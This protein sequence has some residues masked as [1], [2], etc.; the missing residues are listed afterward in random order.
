M[1][2]GSTNVGRRPSGPSPPATPVCRRVAHGSLVGRFVG[3]RYPSDWHGHTPVSGSRRP[4]H[5]SDGLGG[6]PGN[7]VDLTAPLRTGRTH[8]ERKPPPC[9]GEGRGFR[10]PSFRSIGAAERVFL[11]PERMVLCDATRVP[12]CRAGECVH[13]RPTQG[14]NAWVALGMPLSA[15]HR[16]DLIP[17]LVERDAVVESRAVDDLAVAHPHEPGVSVL[18]R[19]VVD[20]R[21]ETVPQNDDGVVVDVD[22]ADGHRSERVS[23]R[24]TPAKRGE[25]RF[26]GDGG[27]RFRLQTVGEAH[28]SHRGS[29][30]T[31]LEM[32][33]SGERR[34]GSFSSSE[35]ESLGV[36]GSR[37][38][39]SG[40][41]GGSRSRSLPIPRAFRPP[42]LHRITA[43]PDTWLDEAGRSVDDPTVLERL[44]RLAIPPAWVDV[45]A[46]ADTDASVQATGVDQRGRTQYRYSPAAQHLA[47]DYKFARM[48]L[49]AAAMPALRLQV[50]HDIARYR[51]DP[52]G[53]PVVTAAIVRLLDRGLLRV[54][55]D[56]YAR[57][58]HTY[59]LTTLRRSHVDTR[60][61]TIT[62]HFIGKERIPHTVTVRDQVTAKVVGALV[63]AAGNET[64]PI[65]VVT[66][67]HG[68]HHVT[69]AAVNAYLHA[70][71]QAP[72]S[73]K[74]FRTWGATV[75]AV[76][77]LA[78]AEAPADVSARSREG[79]AVGA[80]AALLGDT[81]S[82]TRS[83]YIHP[84]WIDV[85]RSDLVAAA[86]V[87]S[88]DRI[89]TR[90]VAS[91]FTDPGVQAAVLSGIT[92]AT[93]EVVARDENRSA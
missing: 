23:G 26:V 32:P 43:R 25:H 31:M 29:T 83:S 5:H 76:A 11:N 14:L 85:G 65:F 57:D 81:S 84:A 70:H 77:V 50:A 53:A 74:V 13:G 86:V 47:S 79:L 39:R 69:S 66:S 87:E 35:A 27:H 24:E 22:A 12:A 72:A 93:T 7:W 2:P 33:V 78:G 89:G 3:T 73:A 16:R 17:E 55:N 18:L 62:F 42:G 46:S 30:L 51:Q 48:T 71:T 41:M 58:N 37:P 90:A 54:G 40:A 59:G 44:R 8:K 21:A 92:D 9:P 63:R 88:S 56:R 4:L 91:L 38:D 61:S 60:G 75:A 64:Q 19:R 45:W 10:I 68:R 20:R 34:V 67:E 52:L 36:G 80:A 82:V 6:R 28:W 15:N 49:F 1:K